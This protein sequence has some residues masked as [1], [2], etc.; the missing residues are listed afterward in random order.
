MCGVGLKV[1]TPHN[2]TGIVHGSPAWRSH[3]TVGDVISEIKKQ[4]IMGATLAE[5]VQKAVV[6]QIN[7]R[8]CCP[9]TA[10]VLILD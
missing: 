9:Q 7:R 4:P 1:N 8:L 10:G 6:C 2:I 5:V 3:L